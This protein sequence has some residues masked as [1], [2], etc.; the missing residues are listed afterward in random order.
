MPRYANY[1]SN[2]TARPL[3]TLPALPFRW[4]GDIKRV[5]S[6]SSIWGETPHTPLDLSNLASHH[7]NVHIHIYP[8]TPSTPTAICFR[9]PGDNE[10]VR[11]VYTFWGQNP[12]PHPISAS[13][14]PTTSSRI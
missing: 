2:P 6:I 5:W 12:L 4:P 14:P 11:L 13:R 10:R 9:W 7:L 1:H 3:S 8:H